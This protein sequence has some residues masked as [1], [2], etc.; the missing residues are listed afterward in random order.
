MALCAAVCRGFIFRAWLSHLD[1]VCSPYAG[2]WTGQNES[3]PG[4][5]RLANFPGC[6]LIASTTLPPSLYGSPGPGWHSRGTF[7]F[8]RELAGAPVAPTL[9]GQSRGPPPRLVDSSACA[10]FGVT[11]ATTVYPSAGYS[12]SESSKNSVPSQSESAS[13]SATSSVSCFE[14]YASPTSASRARVDNSTFLGA[15][16]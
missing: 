6:S 10:T 1:F 4:F 8:V 2:S 11:Q 16:S 9:M 15:G 7:L 12:Q 5:W 3:S 13:G 14:Q